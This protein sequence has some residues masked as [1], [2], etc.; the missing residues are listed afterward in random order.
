MQAATATPWMSVN[1][2]SGFAAGT[3]SPR[4]RVSA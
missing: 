1:V 2:K 4:L 3:P